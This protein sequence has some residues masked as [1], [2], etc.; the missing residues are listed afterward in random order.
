MTPIPSIAQPFPLLVLIFYLAASP[1][2]FLIYAVD[3]SAAI[4]GS[5]RTRERTLH[6][7]ALIGGWPGALIAQKLLRHKSQ[8]RSFQIVFRITVVLHCALLGS[9][10]AFGGKSY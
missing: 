7:L 6:L 2:T 8:K 3:K 10:L 5:R 1:V 4:N 9:L